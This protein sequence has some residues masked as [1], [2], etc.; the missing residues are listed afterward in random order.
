MP[1]YPR[2]IEFVTAK[3]TGGLLDPRLRVTLNFHPDRALHGAP[4]LVSLAADGLYRSQFETGTSNGGLTAYPGGDRW[5]WESRVFGGVYDQ[6]SPRD[7]PKYGA[8]NFRAYSAGGAPRFGSAHFRLAAH[9]LE[10]STFCYPDSV[11]DP[12]NFGVAT[13]MSLPELALADTQ[14]LLDD[15][16]EAQVHGYVVLARDVEALVLDPCFR[17]TDVQAQANELGCPV[18]WHDGF[19]L[20]VDELARHPEYRG[21]EFVALGLELA[22]DGCLDARIIG[23]A[24]RTGHHDPQS[25]KR[26]WHLVARFGL[27]SA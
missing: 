15:Y 10:R 14:D 13:R 9:T 7:R 18:E 27:G 12:V 1:S 4:I 2:A 5:L 23:D 16:V 20:G 22:R 6:A 11:F 21:T 17:G 26:V 3:S 8:L 24:S 19:R 25:L